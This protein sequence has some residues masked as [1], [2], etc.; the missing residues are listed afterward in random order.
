MN[1]EIL[2]RQTRTAMAEELDLDLAQNSLYLS[3]RLNQAGLANYERL[4][5]QAIESYDDQ[6]LANQLRSNGYMKSQETRRKPRGGFSYAK[7]PITAPNTLA[8]GEFNRFYIRGVC[9]RALREGVEEVE[10]YRGKAVTNPR[11]QSNAMIGKR[12]S[13]QTLLNDLRQSPGVGP[14]L[15]V[16]PGPN[17]GLTVRLP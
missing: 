7:V 3:P 17:S 14:A 4:L 10:V 1:F 13:A 8:E 2:D 11:P 12:V 16:P 6:W 15:G 9:V 5:R